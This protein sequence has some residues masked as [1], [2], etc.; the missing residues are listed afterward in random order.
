MGG[1]VLLESFARGAWAEQKPP[2][3]PR[4]PDFGHPA[5]GE[6]GRGPFWGVLAGAKTSIGG[7][8]HGDNPAFR[9]P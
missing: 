5:G 9:G 6:Y 8:V 3:T 2:G 4:T 7:L 1:L